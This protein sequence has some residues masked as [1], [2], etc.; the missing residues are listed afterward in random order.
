M[1]GIFACL[2]NA[3]DIEFDGGEGKNLQRESGFRVWG[4]GFEV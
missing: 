4:L 1:Q 3:A 2:G